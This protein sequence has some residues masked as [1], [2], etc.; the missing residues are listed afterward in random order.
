MP[1]YEY[2]CEDCGR[3]MSFLVFNTKEDLEEGCK[4]CGSKRL[5]RLMSRFAAVRS[6]ESRLESLADPSK[7]GDLDEND[8]KS[9]ARFMK[10]MG[11]ELGEDLGEDFD[12]IIEEAEEEAAR[13]EKEKGESEEE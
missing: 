2:R 6:E 8:P 3:K 7:W 12:Q 4:Y 13:G 5:K 10:K 9:V 11:R 1:I